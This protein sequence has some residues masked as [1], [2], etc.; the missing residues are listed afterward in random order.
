MKLDVT[1]EALRTTVVLNRLDVE[2]K[3]HRLTHRAAAG[4]FH[5]SRDNLSQFAGAA[6]VIAITTV[7]CRNAMTACR[8]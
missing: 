3:V 6:R 5:R 8:Q 4:D 2:A 7:H 1:L